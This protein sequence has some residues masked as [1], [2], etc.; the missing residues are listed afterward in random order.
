M[1]I[2]AIILPLKMPSAALNCP[3]LCSIALNCPQMPLNVNS[4]QLR[5]LNER[6]KREAGW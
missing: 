3:Y 6:P 5:T 1:I 2:P 4:K